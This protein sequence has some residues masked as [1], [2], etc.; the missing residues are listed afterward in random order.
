MAQEFRIVD[1]PNMGPVEFPASMS[2]DDV[3]NVIKTKMMP[4]QAAAQPQAE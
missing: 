4:T 3:A 2:D 1:V